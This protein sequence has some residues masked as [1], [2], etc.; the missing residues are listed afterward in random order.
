MSTV[1][2]I[3]FITREKGYRLE[4]SKTSDGYPYAVL[5]NLRPGKFTIQDLITQW[6]LTD[7]MYACTDYFY[8]FDLRNMTMR[9][10]EAN[11]SEIPW[12]QGELIFDGTVE[13]A[14][15]K[16]Y[17][18]APRPQMPN[19]A[20]VMTH[21]ANPTF[22]EF[23]K[24]KITVR[25]Q[26]VLLDTQ[27]ANI[28]DVSVTEV[29]RVT[30]QNKERF[31]AGFAFRLSRDEIK[32]LPEDLRDGLHFEKNRYLPYVFTEQGFSMLSMHLHSEI[33]INA[34][35]DMVRAITATNTIQELMQ[36][37]LHKL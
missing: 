6:K 20:I 35:L 3:A 9:I 17:L 13:E 21:L 5:G 18:D 26:D 34:N 22:S 37:I 4:F 2:R 16:Y 8:D 28:Y 12:K 14:Y 19:Q 10:W 31:S 30:S 24:Q 33:A 23:D 11:M 7:E 1:A 36:K 29:R 25:S 15:K 27:V 32:S